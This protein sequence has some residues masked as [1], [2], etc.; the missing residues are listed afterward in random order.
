MPPVG[1]EPT[2]AAVE[3]PQTYALDRAATGTGTELFIP[4]RYYEQLGHC[5]Q[6]NRPWGRHCYCHGLQ[7]A[8][9]ALHGEIIL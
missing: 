1:F 8:G 6:S 7:D 3:W 5:W 4:C 2:I 9:S